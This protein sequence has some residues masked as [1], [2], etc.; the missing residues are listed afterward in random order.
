MPYKNKE[1]KYAS[2]QRHRDRNHIALW[3]LLLT[4]E[5][6]DCGYKDPRVLEFDHLPQYQ[7]SFSIANAVSGSTRS[8]SAIQKEI[9]KCEIVCSNCHQIRTMERGDFKRNKSYLAHISALASN[10]LKP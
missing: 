5:C 4:S 6:V 8:W 2:Q 3:N 9:A 1:V 7:K 10:E